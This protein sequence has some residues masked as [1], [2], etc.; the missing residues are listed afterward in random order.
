[1]EDDLDRWEA[2]KAQEAT[3]Q[4]QFSVPQS[5]YLSW[6]RQEL[7]DEQACMEL[8]F[9]ILVVISFTLM[10]VLAL[11]QHVVLSVEQAIEQDIMQ[12]ANFAFNE[13]MGHKTLVDVHSF[14][15]FWSWLRLGFVPLVLPRGWGYS[16]RRVPDVTSVFGLSDTAVQAP[17]AWDFENRYRAPVA[18][19]YL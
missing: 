5:I 14:G 2:R 7:D 13:Y 4:T 11:S 15:D 8:P 6:I 9:M 3:E 1:M 12:N 17:N 10:A 16:E 18:G 19:D